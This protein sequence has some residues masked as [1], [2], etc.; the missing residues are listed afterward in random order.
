[1]KSDEQY[2]NFMHMPYRT[3]W[4]P[5]HCIH[6]TKAK[7]IFNYFPLFADASYIYLFYF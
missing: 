5:M 1:M 7:H 3:W 4:F 2:L 6:T